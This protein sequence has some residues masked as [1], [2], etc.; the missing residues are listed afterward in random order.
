MDA[1]KAEIASKRKALD[2]ASQ[3]PNK[4]MR[5][6]DIEKLKEEE[7]RK[8]REEAA[9]KA[10]DDGALLKVRSTKP[11]SSI[12]YTTKILRRRWSS[13]YRNH[14]PRVSDADVSRHYAFDRLSVPRGFH[15]HTT[16]LE[17]R[18]SVQHLQRRDD[19]ASPCQGPADSSVR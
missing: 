5:R 6:A 16:S 7:E 19:P 13:E 17:P 9:K 12:K 15:G 2:N 10:E 4:Y 18:R 1:L 8:A 3:R 14:Q 11:P